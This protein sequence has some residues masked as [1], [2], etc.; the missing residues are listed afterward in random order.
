MTQVRLRVCVGVGLVAALL[1]GQ[2]IVGAQSSR[3]V[4]KQFK[5]AQYKADVQGDLKG[6]IEDYRRIAD[7]SDRAAAAKA[8]LAMGESYQQL[9]T[10]DARA[11][12]TRVVRDYAEQK[13]VVRAA[14]AKLAARAGARQVEVTPRRVLDGGAASIYSISMDGRLAVGRERSANGATNIVLHD[15]LS[16]RLRALV[17]NSPTGFGFE[18]WI[19][20]D[21]RQV[22]YPW[23][24]TVAGSPGPQMSI[25]IVGTEPGSTPVVVMAPEAMVQVGTERLVARRQIDP[26][27][28]PARRRSDGAWGH[29]SRLAWIS[30]ESK[31][32][33]TIKTFA[34]PVAPGQLLEDARVSPDGR[35]IAFSAPPRSG[36]TDR[37]I[38]VM[39]QAA[40]TRPRSSPRPGPAHR[41][42]GRQTARTCCSSA[43]SQARPACGR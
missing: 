19:S 43:T 42:S 27:A 29:V 18:P 5:A 25:R 3:E 41:Q 21:G 10:G 6:A 8:L 4:E 12:F 11:V 32:L 15:V 14:S 26:C 7:G 31:S 13:D 24:E 20:N 17:A 1:V 22:A 36:S 16:G 30:V 23:R 37:Y 9:G 39:D 28:H 2:A 34:G 35:F 40:S 38:Y 33:R